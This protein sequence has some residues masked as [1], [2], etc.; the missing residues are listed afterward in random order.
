MLRIDARLVAVLVM[1][2]P[3]VIAAWASFLLTAPS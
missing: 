2:A 1:L 3:D